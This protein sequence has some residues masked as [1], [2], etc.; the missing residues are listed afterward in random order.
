[1]F[2]AHVR[3]IATLIGWARDT[4]RGRIGLGGVSLGALNGQLAVRRAAD[5]PENMRPD[6][7][8]LVAT[9]ERLDDLAWSSGFSRG[10]GAA[11]ELA[12]AGWTP[13]SLGEW[14]PLLAPLANRPSTRPDRRGAGNGRYDHALRRRPGLG[15]TLAHPA[16][17]PVRELRGH[18]T[19][20]LDLGRDPAPYARL[21]EILR[22]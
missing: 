4:G 17:E 22:S 6:A 2:A 18:F 19:K 5:W 12:R 1:M 15:A 20:I 11:G 21:V 16:G 8:L 13:E 7:A 9:T 14:T 10:L 3:E